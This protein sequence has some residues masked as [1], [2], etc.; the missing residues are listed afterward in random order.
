MNTI[1]MKRKNE[2]EVN[3]FPSSYNYNYTIQYE[4]VL[5][6]EIQAIGTHNTHIAIKGLLLLLLFLS[7][8][9]SVT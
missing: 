6:V 5:S 3:D 8:N 9:R 7:V 1:Q 4:N 2:I